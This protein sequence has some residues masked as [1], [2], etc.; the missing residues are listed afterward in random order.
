MP[1]HFS[2]SQYACAHPVPRRSDITGWSNYRSA[3][4]EPEVVLKLLEDQYDKRHCERFDSFEELLAFLM[5]DTA[6][7]SKLAL[8]SKTK[9]DGTVKH[10]L[11]WDLLRSSVNE[12]VRLPERIVLPR[13]QDAVE[14]AHELLKW[15]N[16][17]D[18][19]WAVLDI[20]DAFH[21]IPIRPTEQPFAYGSF[22]GKYWVFMVLCMGAEEFLQRYFAFDTQQLILRCYLKICPLQAKF[23][24][25]EIVMGIAHIHDK[26]MIF[27][28]LKDS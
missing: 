25:A 11:I 8:V 3:E 14:D 18:L 15:A 17:E 27:R 9:E 22:A 2:S 19:E 12:A 13:I 10:R 24:T 16:G 20:A 21:N 28:D 26:G 1:K 23:Y 7:L 5:V 6:V 4:D